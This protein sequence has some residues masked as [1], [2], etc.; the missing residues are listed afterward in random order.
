MARSIL[1]FPG[2][3]SVAGFPKLDVSQAEIDVA[4]IEGRRHWPGLFDWDV[5]TGVILDRITDAVIP[6]YGASVPSA[7]F[8]TMV[9]GKKGYKVN[10]LAQALTMG[11][12][13]TAGSF[14][15]GLVCDLHLGLGSIT[16]GLT[17]DNLAPWV[18]YSNA[19]GSGAITV[20]IG[21]ITVSETTS[22]G[23]PQKLSSTKLTAFVMIYDRAIG[24][25]SIRYNGAEMWSVTNEAW[26]ALGLMPE[27]NMGAVR[28]AGASTSVVSR[29]MSSN[30]FV[31]FESALSGD[32][33][34]ALEKM[35]MEAAAA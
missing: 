27:L 11:S 30:A 21:P 22:G 18:I 12:F 33:L 16:Q 23:W 24:R 9:N 5:S 17:T 7:N 26:K 13:D 35:L 29:A 34:I 8:V 15:I 32:N 31:A 1:T 28:V 14:T 20:N 25:I 4:N 19:A 2:S 6:T 3:A 10:A